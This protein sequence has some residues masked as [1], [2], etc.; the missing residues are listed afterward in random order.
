MTGPDPEDEVTLHMVVAL[1]KQRH[2]SPDVT[3]GIGYTLIAAMV[4]DASDDDKP[5]LLCR[6]TAA[7]IQLGEDL[8]MQVQLDLDEPQPE[9]MQ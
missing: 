3:C 1:L 9:T 8:G 7:L 5:I 4:R 2:A 6:V